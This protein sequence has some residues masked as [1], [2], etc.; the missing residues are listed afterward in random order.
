MKDFFML[1]IT[2]TLNSSLIL[3]TAISLFTTTNISYAGSC[4]NS[5]QETLDFRAEAELGLSAKWRASPE[6]FVAELMGP[7]PTKLVNLRG[8][9]PLGVSY[10]KEGDVVLIAF[11]HSNANS[12]EILTR[13]LEQRLQSVTIQ[14]ND[15]EAKRRLIEDIEKDR[16]MLQEFYE[17]RQ[18]FGGTL[19]FYMRSAW[20]IAE[21]N[22]LLR[23]QS[24]LGDYLA[25]VEK[26]SSLHLSGIRVLPPNS[27]TRQNLQA[28]VREIRSS[29]AEITSIQFR[30]RKLEDSAKLRESASYTFFQHLA[31][32]TDRE[33][34]ILGILGRERHPILS[35]SFEMAQTCQTLPRQTAGRL[36]VT[37][38][39]LAPPPVQAGL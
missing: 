15:P 29:G 9:G 25:E 12:R 19:Q 8:I 2:P 17:L 22:K 30:P 39:P 11:R 23:E 24:L 6:D 37:E 4:A 20:G 27:A 1:K 10:P 36:G 5:E 3:A 18:R 34:T 31:P 16:A 13:R 32:L 14:L 38:A 35:N 26:D 7:N 33:Q 28:A 21:R